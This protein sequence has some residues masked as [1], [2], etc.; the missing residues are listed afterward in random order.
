[1]E[2]INSTDRLDM[3]RYTRRVPPA[4]FFETVN[5]AALAET[6]LTKRTPG[7]DTV[8]VLARNLLGAAR[9]LLAVRDAL[10]DTQFAIACHVAEVSNG[11]DPTFADLLATL[12]KVGQPVTEDMLAHGRAEQAGKSVVL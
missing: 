12:T 8:Y 5:A 6:V 9:A 1:M 4:E 3:Q 11:E 10:T 7:P 2:P